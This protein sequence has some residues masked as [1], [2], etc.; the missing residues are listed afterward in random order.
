MLIKEYRK[1]KSGS[2][3]LIREYYW[4]PVEVPENERDTT[5]ENTLKKI[6]HECPGCGK[7]FTPM[8]MRAHECLGGTPEYPK[9]GNRRHLTYAEPDSVLDEYIRRQNH[10]I[11]VS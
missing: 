2:W 4:F 3:Q 10:K 6:R 5:S 9:L 7:S 11:V 1:F 8:F